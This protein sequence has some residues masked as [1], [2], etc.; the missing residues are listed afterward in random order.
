M[1]EERQAFL[2]ELVDKNVYILN[3]NIMK[4]YQAQRNEPE[5]DPVIDKD[6]IKHLVT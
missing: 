4:M 3:S 2:K 5:T 1:V 6:H